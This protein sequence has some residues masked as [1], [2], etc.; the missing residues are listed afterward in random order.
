MSTPSQPKAQPWPYVIEDGDKQI[1]IE[2]PVS[3]W[4]D[5]DD[6][7]HDEAKRVAALIASAPTLQAENERLREALE[8]LDQNLLVN[9]MSVSE[10]RGIIRAALTRGA[11]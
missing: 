5:Y 11:P 9:R 6:V 3:V 7:D 10:L 2:A 4:V 1:L 8:C